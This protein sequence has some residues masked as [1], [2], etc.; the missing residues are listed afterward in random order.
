MIVL[1]FTQ[2]EES[3]PLW[4]FDCVVLFISQFW[5]KETYM[6]CNGTRKVNLPER[7]RGALK[8]FSWLGFQNFHSKKVTRIR[9]FLQVPWAAS[10][11]RGVSNSVSYA[12]S[13]R[14]VKAF[15]PSCSCF[16]AS[17]RAASHLSYGKTLNWKCFEYLTGF[18][19]KGTNKLNLFVLHLCWL[20]SPQP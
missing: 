1:V 17:L 15:L 9:E 8:G 6:F 10:S 2:G 11:N 5:I 14:P 13:N 20:S 3:L 18:G 4:F 7:Q 12:F 19:V 16:C